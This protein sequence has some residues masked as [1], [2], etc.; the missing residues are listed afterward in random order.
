MV[1]THIFHK[2]VFSAR[3]YM[4]MASWGFCVL[5]FDSSG[6]PANRPEE[7]LC[8]VPCSSGTEFVVGRPT[9]DEEAVGASTGASRKSPS[10]V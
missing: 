7:M 6:E 2:L 5:W 8:D 1:V 9:S 10:T 3:I 4:K